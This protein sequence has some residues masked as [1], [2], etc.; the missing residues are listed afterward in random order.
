MRP[1][2]LSMWAVL[3]G[4]GGPLERPTYIAVVPDAEVVDAA[5]P[6][7]VGPWEA[8]QSRATV[9]DLPGATDDSARPGDLLLENDHLQTVVA[10]VDHYARG[11]RSGGHLIA[12]VARG[13]SDALGELA[14]TLDPTGRHVPVFTSVTVAQHGAGGGP[15]IVRATGHHPVD[16]HVKVSID[17]VLEPDAHVVRLVVTVFNDT[18][19]HFP[20]ATVGAY[21]LWGG[22][23]PFV[24]GYGETVAGRRTRSDW[25]GGDG[26]EAGLVIA[27]RSGRLVATHGRDWSLVQLKPE[28]LRP[29]STLV[30]ELHLYAEPGGVA[31]GVARLYDSR[32]TVVG[33]IRGV[34]VDRAGAPVPGARVLATTQRGEALVRARTD[35][36]GRFVARIRPGS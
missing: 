8:G 4:C 5:P 16:E 24:P 36:A 30:G 10:G 35:A 9:I 33:T 34:V 19:G 27:A 7:V 23:R 28:H 17:Y 22:L 2:T 29:G 25:V 31:A 3:I 13:G 14:V 18:R 1:V 12:T 6:L 11:A 32:R 15:A 20:G 26:P 21:M